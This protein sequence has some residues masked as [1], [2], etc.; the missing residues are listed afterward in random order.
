MKSAVYNPLF[1][2]AKRKKM[3]LCHRCATLTVDELVENDVLFQPNLLALKTSAEQ[4]CE[5]CLLCWTALQTVNQPQLDRLLQGQS[6][7]AEGEDWTPTMWLRG[8]HFFDHGK[9][10]ARIEISCGIT[11]S[12]VASGNRELYRNPL[13]Y[14]GDG[15]EVYEYEPGDRSFNVFMW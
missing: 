7:W 8:M 15:L 14:V 2:T 5:F 12:V 6:A 11:S 1:G 9:S 4:G 13:P 3:P 10:G